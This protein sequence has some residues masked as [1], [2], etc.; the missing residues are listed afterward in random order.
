M[1]YTKIYLENTCAVELVEQFGN[2]LFQG[3]DWDP[4]QQQTK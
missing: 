3:T 1:E 4:Y 2:S